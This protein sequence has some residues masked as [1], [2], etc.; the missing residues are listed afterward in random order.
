MNGKSLI[1]CYTKK[2]SFTA[3]YVYSDDGDTSHYGF[4]KTRSFTVATVS[5]A[6]NSESDLSI[7]SLFFLFI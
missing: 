7:L 3:N 4:F 2:D 1:E 6:T 5:V